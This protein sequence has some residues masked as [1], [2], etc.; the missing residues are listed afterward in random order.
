MLRN[1]W[2]KTRAWTSVYTP[3]H[4]HTHTFAYFCSSVSKSSVN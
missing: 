4:R 3:P 2:H 1:C